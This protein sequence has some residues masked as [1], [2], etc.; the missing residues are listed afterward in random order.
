MSR[1]FRQPGQVLE[2]T[3]GT[4]VDIASGEVVIMG[5][6][7]GV[8]L[9]D[10]PDGETGNVSIHGVHE[11]AKTGAQAWTQG[12]IVNWDSDNTE[13]TTATPANGVI[14]AGK[15]ALDAGAADATAEVL[16]TPDAAAAA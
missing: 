8:A 11:L 15:A 9:V 12:E 13:F 4:G 14:L 10:I 3:N 7:V 5:D 2:F 6:T 1:T 16:L